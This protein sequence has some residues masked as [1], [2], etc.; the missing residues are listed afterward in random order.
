MGL[1]M[2]DL[3]GSN[4][5]LVKNPKGGEMLVPLNQR[6]R[7]PTPAEDHLPTY[8][9]GSVPSPEDQLRPRYKR[10]A[11]LPR[12]STMPLFLVLPYPPP[13][14]NLYRN[15][16][17]KG[18][19]KTDRAKQYADDVARVAIATQA[20]PPLAKAV[21]VTLDV[22][23]PRKRGDLD[24]T[25]KAILDAIQGIAWVDDEQVVEIHMRRHL[26]RDDPRVELTVRA[27]CPME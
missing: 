27:A 3:K 9:D 11:A 7:P 5:R 8:S 24:G 15:V 20:L 25:A 26:D 4:L 17:G 13:L 22:Y 16:P 10:R 12:Q 6:T 14:N 19:V 23:R 21:S 2:E 18:R 1:R